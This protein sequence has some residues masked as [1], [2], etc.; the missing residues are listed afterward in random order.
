MNLKQFLNENTNSLEELFKNN[1]N[2]FI[3]ESDKNFIYRGLQFPPILSS[4]EI[5]GT[6]IE[7]KISQL[8]TDRKPMNTSK[9]IS[10]GI[11]N[12]FND[13]FNFKARSSAIFCVGKS[14]KK[15]AREYGPLYIIFPM[16]GYK[17]V[18]SNEVEDLYTVLY[19]TSAT[20]EKSKNDKYSNIHIEYGK[21]LKK[22]NIDNNKIDIFMKNLNY[23]NNNLEEA[24]KSGNEIMI[25]TPFY[26]AIKYTEEVE[27]EL[28]NL[29]K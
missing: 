15:I 9:I 14:G 22:G 7:Y 26:I 4:T 27:T 8:R 23:K 28:K 16:N 18:W 20:Y 5:N 3:I 6:K 2:E 19:K 24:I 1:Y 13:V 17:Y 11:D 21:L 29:I 10:S 25:H 12:W